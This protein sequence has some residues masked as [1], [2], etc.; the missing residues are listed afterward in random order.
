MKS[1]GRRADNEKIIFFGARE[2]GFAI[3]NFRMAG[4]KSEADMDKQ[5][6]HFASKCHGTSGSGNN[7]FRSGRKAENSI[8]EIEREQSGFLWIKLHVIS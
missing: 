7:S 4:G 2:A 3:R 1:G 5:I 6:F 8:L